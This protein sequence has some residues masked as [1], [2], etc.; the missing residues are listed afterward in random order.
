MIKKDA[1]K[2]RCEQIPKINAVSRLWINGA[3]WLSGKH[4]R[5]FLSSNQK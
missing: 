5:R 3:F 2:P 4:Q 1:V